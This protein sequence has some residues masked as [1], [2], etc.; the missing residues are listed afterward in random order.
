[1]RR[2]FTWHDGERVIR[3]GRG[4]LRDAPALLRDGYALVTTDRALA[5]AP[6]LAQ[7]AGSVHRIGAGDVA[8][9]AGDLLAV[10]DARLVVG[11]GGGRVIDTVKA[12]AAAQ[13][14]GGGAGG[15][16][17]ASAGRVRA[18]AVPTTLSAAEMTWLHRQAR[19]APAGSG[20]ARAAIVLN[21]P[22]LSASQPADALASSAA[23]SLAHAV[24]GVATTR[25]S[26]VPALAARAAVG[27]TAGAYAEPDAP[28]RD[29]LAL[30]A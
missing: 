8:D 26:P 22:A 23:N 10:V 11:L 1:M 14:A 12:V 18:A 15:A 2:D 7:R 20:H 5:Q 24:D 4:A 29:D 27:L 13:A 25:A 19:G 28:A 30:A 6:E 3:F 17:G 16:G 21:D 9:L